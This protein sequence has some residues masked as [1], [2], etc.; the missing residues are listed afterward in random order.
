[1]SEPNVE[2]VRRLY[3]VTNDGDLSAVLKMVSDDVEL[4]LFG[5]PKVPWA[6]HWRG[7]RV[8]E[9]ETQITAFR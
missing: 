8:D 3:Q 5:S 9:L 6:G 1:M 7:R 2:T 4:F